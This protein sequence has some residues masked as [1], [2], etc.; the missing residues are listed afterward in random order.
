MAKVRTSA[1]A[2]A[3]WTPLSPITAGSMRMRGIKQIPLLSAE[4]RDAF[5]LSP[6]LCSI[7]LVQTERGWKKKAMH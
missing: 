3:I 7:M 5:L 4:R 6:T 2:C 1:T